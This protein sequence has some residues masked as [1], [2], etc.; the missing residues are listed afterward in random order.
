DRA[1]SFVDFRVTEYAGLSQSNVLEAVSSASGAAPNANSGSVS[2]TANND[3]IFGA[4][5]TLGGFSAP[6][7][8]FVQRVLT[9]PDG[10]NVEDQVAPGSGSYE[11]T[12]ICSGAWLMQVAAFRAAP[13]SLTIP[14]QITGMMF[15]NNNF[16][17]QF[18]TVVGQ[19]YELDSAPDLTGGAWR[20]VVIG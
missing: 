3:L 7:G 20:P 12:A 5:Y 17:V 16:I 2:T 13:P 10:D 4:G 19:T 18:S 15:S 11:A 8:G 14:P 9:A 6:G 1:A